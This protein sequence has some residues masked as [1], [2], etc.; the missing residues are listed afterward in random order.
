ML[1]FFECIYVCLDN[2]LASCFFILQS[3]YR[4]KMLQFI[5]Q[6]FN[7]SFNINKNFIGSFLTI[8]GFSIPK[9]E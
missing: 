1:R 2:F 8:L 9:N 4:F 7:S 6:M 5:C 3:S